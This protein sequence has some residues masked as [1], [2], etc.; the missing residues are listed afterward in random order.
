M[1]FRRLLLR[2]VALLPLPLLAAAMTNEEGRIFLEDNSSASGVYALSS[3][4]QYKKLRK[5][6]GANHPAADA[7]CVVNYEG[8]LLDGT[9]FESKTGA[10]VVPKDAPLEGWTIALQRM[11]EGDQWELYL[12]SE[13]GY[14]G[15]DSP[16]EIRGGE[17]LVFT[18]EL[19][20]IE[21]D[22]VPKDQWMKDMGMDMHEIHAHEAREAHWHDGGVSRVKTHSDDDGPSATTEDGSSATTQGPA[23]ESNTAMIVFVSCSISVFATYLMMRGG[24]LARASIGGGNDAR[25]R[26]VR[27]DDGDDDDPL[28]GDF[29]DGGASVEMGERG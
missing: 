26:A 9:V 3:G 20:E 24:G 4:L 15:R 16:K 11:V 25:Y 8:R 21:G 19:L 13:L 7:T 22:V 27:M 29:G 18:M 17:V 6:Q 5:G 10:R 28:D 12:P 1:N 23:A 14:G 2:S